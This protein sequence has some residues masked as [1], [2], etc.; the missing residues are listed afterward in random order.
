MP[1]PHDQW[2]WYGY[3]G[4][5]VGGS[6]CAFHLCT[7]IGKVMISTIGHYI[8][9]KKDDPEPLGLGPDSLFETMVFRCDGEEPTGDAII[10][11]WDSIDGERYAESKPAE[12]GHHRYCKKWAEQQP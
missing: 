10:P 6:R 4:H 5:F 3:A 12:D 2:K 1:I 7:R 8:P 9:K 11:S